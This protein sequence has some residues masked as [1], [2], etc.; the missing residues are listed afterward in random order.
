MLSATNP[1]EFTLPK[2]GA[3]VVVAMSGGVDSSVAAAWLKQQ[4]YDVIGISLQLHDMATKI[5]NKFGTCCSLT[6]IQDARRVAES[7][8]FPFY[9][10][11]M[12][13]EFEEAVID[14][15]VTEYVNGRT[16]NPCVR[17]NEKVKFKRLMDWAMD[18]DA[19]YLATGHYA[20]IRWNAEA[21]R[22][23]LCRGTD[24][25][26]DQSYFLFTM[27]DQDLSRTLFPVGNFQKN[28][29]RDLAEKLGLL[30][31]SKKPDSQE[32]CFVQARNYKEFIEA[33]V[34]AGLLKPGPIVTLDGTLVGEHTGLHQ[35]TIGQRKGLGVPT[36][37]TSE[38]PVFVVDINN[39]THT[40]VV[41]PEGAL[42]KN[43]AVLS[44]VHW[45]LPPDF[46][47]SRSFEAKIRYRSQASPV[48]VLPLIDGKVE[49]TFSQ[50][51]RAITP[52]QAVVFYRGD[53]VYGGGWIDNTERSVAPLH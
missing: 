7:C 41:G 39:E 28:Q 13:K 52:G 18:L 8:D 5:E 9:V 37:S 29:V 50:P 36:K 53:T 4:G 47:T 24:P 21:Q 17:C 16:P 12:E 40:V 27:R 32:I 11:D 31:V 34:P 19:E 25:M 43:K 30:S 42:L 20:Q 23:E 26:K 51:Q 22:N 46:N 6:D 35:F 44:D 3:R 1:S 15:F 45:I 48:E 33:R 14:D 38:E 49:V 2:K 10:T